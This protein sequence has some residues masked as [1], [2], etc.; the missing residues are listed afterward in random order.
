MRQPSTP[1]DGAALIRGASGMSGLRAVRRRR[2]R[3]AGCTAKRAGSPAAARGRPQE[4]IFSVHQLPGGPRL[5]L[6]GA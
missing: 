2:C 6:R 5:A 3:P 1:A 4:P